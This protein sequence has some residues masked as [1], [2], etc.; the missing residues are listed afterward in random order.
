VLAET[1]LLSLAGGALGVV[2]AFWGLRALLALSPDVLPRMGEVTLSMPVL[3]FSVGV[4][5]LVAG[6]LGGFSGLRSSSGLQH[7]LAAGG[8][9]QAGA[10]VSQRLSRAIVA[11][12][13]AVTLTLLTAAALL[14]RSLVNVL[15]VNPGFT[16]EHVITMNLGLPR[17]RS[18]PAS[19]ACGSSTSCSRASAR[20]LVSTRSAARA[21]C[22]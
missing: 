19:V 3:L 8:R 18:A 5:V 21:I 16:T 20:F 22:R 9:S 14:G 11:G 7:A 15:S 2:T 1:L 17:A 12:Q 4:C 13:L 10:F 6:A